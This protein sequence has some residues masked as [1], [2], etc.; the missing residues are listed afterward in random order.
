MDRSK[1]EKEKSEELWMMNEN[2]ITIKVETVEKLTA[3]NGS[4]KRTKNSDGV[5]D[6]FLPSQAQASKRRTS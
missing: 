1:R 3:K 5:S 4:K 6:I 2:K